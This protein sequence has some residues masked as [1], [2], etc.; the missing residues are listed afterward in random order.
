MD[1]L[2]LTQQESYTVLIFPDNTLINVGFVEQTLT[3][4]GLESSI[5]ELIKIGFMENSDFLYVKPYSS[6]IYFRASS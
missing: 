6:R 5:S 2:I 3:T 1:L 4:V